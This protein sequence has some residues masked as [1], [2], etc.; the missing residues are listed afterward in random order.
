MP[1][2][3]GVIFEGTADLSSFCDKS[4]VPSNIN[5]PI[6]LIYKFHGK[7]SLYWVHSAVKGKQSTYIMYRLIIISLPKDYVAKWQMVL[8]DS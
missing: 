2:L 3:F 4:A 8:H 7:L 1:Y 5:Y 6:L